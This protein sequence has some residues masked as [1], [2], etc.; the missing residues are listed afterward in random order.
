MNRAAGGLAQAA[1]GLAGD[2][3]AGREVG[4]PHAP[5]TRAPSGLGQAGAEE[6]RGVG[7]ALR[8]TGEAARAWMDVLRASGGGESTVRVSA[9]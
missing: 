7:L 6:T 4:V 1:I 8:L 3:R 2:E 5:A 9:R